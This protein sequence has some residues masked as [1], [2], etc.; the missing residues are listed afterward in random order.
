MVGAVVESVW[1]M[2][3][4]D[5]AATSNRLMCGSGYATG[6]GRTTKKARKLRF[7]CM[8]T[9]YLQHVRG[10]DILT[11]LETNQLQMN[12]Q[13]GIA[14]ES[15]N[16][17]PFLSGICKCHGYSCSS[18]N[19]NGM[20]WCVVYVFCCG[21]RIRWYRV[22]LD[23][24]YMVE[25]VYCFGVKHLLCVSLIVSTSCITFLNHRTFRLHANCRK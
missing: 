1:V 22:W 8:P 14:F 9:M 16:D 2:V 12:T 3:L 10:N 6:S 19:K 18:A 7:G 4:F 21:C 11:T 13:T 20:I 25:Y 17:W 24:N 15:K 5:Y 23:L